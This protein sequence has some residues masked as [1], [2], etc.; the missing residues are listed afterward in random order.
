MTPSEFSIR[1]S[2]TISVLIVILIIAGIYSYVV[3]PRESFPDITIPN[4]LVTTNYEGVAP[5]DIES[6]ITIQIEKKL[7]SLSKVKEIRSYSSEGAS[8]IVI[9]YDSGIDIDTALQ[10]VRDKVDEAKK[11]LP[12]DLEDDPFVKEI[13]FAEFPIMNVVFSGPVGLVRLKEIA[14]DF[15][16]DV[17]TINGVLEAKVTGGLEREIRVVYDPERLAAYN[18]S[19]TQVMQAVRSNNLNTPGGDMDIGVGNYLLKI[20]GEFQNPEEARKLIVF[21]NDNVPVYVT[22]VAQLQDGF[23]EPKTKARYNGHEAVTVSVIKRSGENIIEIADQVKALIHQY[24]QSTPY[25]TVISVDTD[26]SKDINIMVS[27]LENSILSGLILVLLVVLFSMGLRNA[28]LVASAIPLSMLI[29]FM[30]LKLMG[31][32][33][34]MVVLFSLVLAVGMLVDNAIVIVENI[35]RHRQ[36]GKDRLTASIV[37]THEVM[38]PVIASAATT[39][40][41]FFPMVYWPGIV[42]EFMAYLPKTVIVALTASLFVALIINPTLCSLFVKAKSLSPGNSKNR[43]VIWYTHLLEGAVDRPFYTLLCSLCM[44]ILIVTAYVRFGTGV[45]FFPE[46]EPQRAYI[47]IEMPKGTNLDQTDAMTRRVEKP[48]SEYDEVKSIITNI[49]TTG[50]SM[51]SFGMVSGN[52]P[53]ISRIMLEF[54]DIEDRKIP[55]SQ[56]I[57]RLRQTLSPIYEADIE[58]QKEEGGPPTGAP[59]SI[60]ISGESYDVLEQ[61]MREAKER[62]RAIP[63]LVNLQDDYVVARPEIVVNVDKER[64]ALLGLNTQVVATNVK[65][66]IRGIEAGVYREGND[67]YDIIVQL[68]L[69]RRKDL[70]ALKNLMI[71]DALGRYVPI[72]SIADI[73]LSAGLGTIV[74]SD[75]KRVITIEGEVEGRLATDVLTDVQNTLT[76]I[77]LPRGYRLEYRGESEDREEAQEFLSEAFIAAL[78]LI[79]LILVTEFNSLYK[80]FIILTS[81]ILA[82]VGVFIGLLVTNT[83]FGI[84]MTGIGVISLAGVVVNNAIVLL[85]YVGQLRE[86][87]VSA[88]DSLVRAGIVR[89]RP[90]MLTAITT[91]LG[92]APMAVGISYDFRNLTWQVDSESSQ[93][94]GPMAVAVIF[95]LAVATL[96]TLVVVPSMVSAGDAVTSLARQM[97]NWITGRTERV[98]V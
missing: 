30:V 48:S 78:M 11:D 69:D 23:E 34:N 33:L 53:D 15:A 95:G 14:D 31:L 68:P 75:Q 44:M 91:I 43:L 19:V 76:A 74:R 88:R 92:L 10:K 21:S 20:P 37:G 96:L 63:G 46:V 66:A 65:A 94:W 41:A 70:Y 98:R 81:V 9:E 1:H 50:S 62:I 73:R 4:V 38:W 8:T 49:G 55:S 22:D 3:L 93:W 5:S 29:T 90:V 45:E 79:M 2:T 25:G 83:P 26:M 32:T 24:Q 56:V 42:G 80:P 12:S 39:I 87:G 47:D 16:D 57:A 6:Q 60:E 54:V 36:E 84:I 61:I 64:A 67:D 27:D 35:F 82:T 71:S 28:L 86:R 97:R 72:S 51:Q 52:S 77:Q 89:F 40:A 18:I 58:I 17:E 7:I 59:V 13:N 85:D